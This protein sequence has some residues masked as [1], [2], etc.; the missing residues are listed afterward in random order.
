MWKSCD[1]SELASRYIKLRSTSF[2]YCELV[3]QQVV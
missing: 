3:E 1:N 2:V